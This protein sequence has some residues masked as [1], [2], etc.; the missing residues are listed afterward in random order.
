M[1]TRIVVVMQWL[2]LALLLMT[3][4]LYDRRQYSAAVGAHQALTRVYAQMSVERR[5]VREVLGT[6]GTGE[7]SLPGMH[8]HVRR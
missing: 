3:L 7:R 5:L 4:Q 8:H 1:I 2:V 6:E